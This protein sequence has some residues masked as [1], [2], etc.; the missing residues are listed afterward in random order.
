MSWR[1]RTLGLSVVLAGGCGLFDFTEPTSETA[2]GG[3]TSDGGAAPVNVSSGGRT[4]SGA[5]EAGQSEGGVT[6][7]GQGG[8][9]AKAGQAA[10]GGAG[11][12]GRGGATAGSGASAGTTGG[13]I[14]GLA[15]AGGTP[16]FEDCA[17]AAP[18]P[19]TPT[20]LDVFDRQGTA[21]GSNWDPEELKVIGGTATLHPGYATIENSSI[22][23]VVEW[24][25]PST[26]FGDAQEVWAQISNIN[27]DVVGV[28][29]WMRDGLVGVLYYPQ[30][31]R[32][33]IVYRFDSYPDLVYRTDVKLVTSRPVVFG[34]RAFP[35]GCV[36]LFVDGELL[37]HGYLQ[38]GNPV[39]PAKYYTSDG[40]IGMAAEG[41]VHFERFGGGTLRP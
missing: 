34:G 14:G 27:S 10:T 36:Q 41:P 16:G 19:S 3:A 2:P 38:N 32:L 29:L 22:G 8:S 7:T 1:W 11:T 35:D 18:F 12:A 24:N 23:N 39:P 13:S 5:G 30:D 17:V 40:R 20:A 6:E 9:G 4:S 31:P 15:G 37:L 28:A 26:G 33:S 25:A 21:L